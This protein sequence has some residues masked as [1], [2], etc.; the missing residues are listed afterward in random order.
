MTKAFGHRGLLV[1]QE[2][3]DLVTEIYRLT[4]TFAKEELF[5]LSVQLRHAAISVPSNI[6]EGAARISHKEFRHFLS[7]ARGRL[8]KLRRRFANR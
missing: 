2:A 4:K 7:I 8:Q 1:W 6:A 5:G 3:M